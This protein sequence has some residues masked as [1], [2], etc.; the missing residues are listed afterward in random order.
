M[1][2]ILFKHSRHLLVALAVFDSVFLIFATI[3]V[4]PMSIHTLVSW[5]LFNTF[6]THVALYI[7]TF[8]S[9]FYKASVL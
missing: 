7:R 3:E 9:T 5:E 8:A 2:F 1:L 4:M 6:Y